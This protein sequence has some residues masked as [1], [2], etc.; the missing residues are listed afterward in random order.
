MIECKVV[1]KNNL[2]ENED[3]W[4]ENHEKRS[5]WPVYTLSLRIDDGAPLWLHGWHYVTI[6]EDG[7]IDIYDRDGDGYG[8][9]RIAAGFVH[10]IRIIAWDEDH[11]I[12]CAPG[13]VY[14][15][16]QAIGNAAD[17]IDYVDPDE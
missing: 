11:E 17:S 13:R 15:L 3:C 12:D 7:D 10:N 16:E 4:D 1:S 5:Y 2:R 9:P 14:E 8:I 6:D